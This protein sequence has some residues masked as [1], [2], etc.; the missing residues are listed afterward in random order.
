MYAIYCQNIPTGI[1]N[2]YN[3]LTIVNQGK[4]KKTFCKMDF[5]DLI[6]N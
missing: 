1:I 3:S 2:T 6:L 4:T 5:I